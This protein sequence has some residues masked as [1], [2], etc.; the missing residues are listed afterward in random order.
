MLLFFCCII[1]RMTVVFW[2]N[3]FLIPICK[4]FGTDT[5]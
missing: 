2:T 5:R 4:E 1:V 3:V